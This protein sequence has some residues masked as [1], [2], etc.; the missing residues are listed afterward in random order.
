MF[1]NFYKAPIFDILFIYTLKK[2]VILLGL[3]FKFVNCASFPQYWYIIIYIPFDLMTNIHYT[4]V[5]W[6]KYPI[7]FSYF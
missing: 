1:D 6:I 2:D 4:D 5:S 7:N 3:V